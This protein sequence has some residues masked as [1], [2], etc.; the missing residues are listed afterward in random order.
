MRMIETVLLPP[1]ALTKR[2][3]NDVRKLDM[4]SLEVGCLALRGCCGSRREMRGKGGAG[5]IEDGGPGRFPKQQARG[6]RG[7]MWTRNMFL[8]LRSK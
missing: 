7:A 6:W 1:L 4:E 5:F 2:C 8:K 3:G